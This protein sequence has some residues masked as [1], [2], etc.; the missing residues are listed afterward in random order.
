MKLAAAVAWPFNNNGW[1]LS[2]L[3]RI[4]QRLLRGS[5]LPAVLQKQE[6]ESFADRVWTILGPHLFLPC[7]E[8]LFHVLLA[9]RQMPDQFTQL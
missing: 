9:S 8:P 4:G 6:E 1:E 7:R 5:S 3:V 2:A